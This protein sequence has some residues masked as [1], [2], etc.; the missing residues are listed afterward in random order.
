MELVPA[1]LFS[2]VEF[3][4]LKTRPF[5]NVDCIMLPF[6]HTNINSRFLTEMCIIEF[7]SHLTIQFPQ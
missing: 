7:F 4:D 6:V 1:T 2:V 5:G 3:L